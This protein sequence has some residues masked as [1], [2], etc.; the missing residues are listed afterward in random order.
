MKD[1][2]EHLPDRKREDLRRLTE[3]IREMSND[4]EMVVPQVSH[5]RS[6]SALFCRVG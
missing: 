5:L 2:L 3:V 1:S 4:V 6:R